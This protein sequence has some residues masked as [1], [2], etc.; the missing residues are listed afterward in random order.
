M[1]SLT[2]IEQADSNQFTFYDNHMGTI[3]RSVEGFEFATVRQSID[4]VAG[5][6]GATYITSKFGTR[7]CSLSGDLIGSNVFTLRQTLLK[8]LRQTGTIKLI[9]FTTY[10][11][12]DL[13]FEAEVIKMVSPYNHGV[14]SYMINFLAPDWRFYSQ[15]LQSFDLVQTI[16]QGGTSIPAIIPM[17]FPVP[18]DPSTAMNNIITNGGNEVTDPIFTITG[19]GTN[20]TVENVTTGKSFILTTALDPGDGFRTS[21]HQ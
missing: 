9:K 7:Q 20:F 3:I 21:C 11:D 14:H 2:I 4:D 12:I 1:K 15:I 18:T 19:P 16:L 5:P 13:Q 10:D 17:G 8:A 6:Y